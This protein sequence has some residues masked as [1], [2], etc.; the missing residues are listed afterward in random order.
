MITKVGLSL[1]NIKLSNGIVLKDIDAVLFDRD[2]VII[3]ADK[4]WK[5]VAYTWAYAIV[6]RFSLSLDEREAICKAMGF[7]C[8]TSS[9]LPDGPL[10]IHGYKEVIWAVRKYL[11]HT[12]GIQATHYDIDELFIQ[13][14]NEDTDKAA[15]IVVYQDVVDFF[16]TL[17]VRG[18]KI[19][20][21][22]HD[23]ASITKKMLH[24]LGLHKYVQVVI[25]QEDTRS[26]ME[27]GEPARLALKELDSLAY[28][29]VII[30]ARRGG[31]RMALASGVAAGI[32]RWIKG[33]LPEGIGTP[34]IEQSFSVLEVRNE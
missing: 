33:P 12:H 34:F 14:N 29:S 13:A 19:G 8:A 32:F 17:H 21:I 10:S 25:G 24:Q 1:V 5:H 27:T 28:N 9:L 30:S 23:S 26:T 15:H 7:S 6:N 4:W 3:N 22:T 18:A 2:D 16:A 20:V 31:I 11:L